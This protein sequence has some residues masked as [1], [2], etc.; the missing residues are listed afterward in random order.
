M[1]IE[2]G[3]AEAIRMVQHTRSGDPT[4]LLN[5]MQTEQDQKNEGEGQDQNL[6]MN[7][8]IPN[9]LLMDEDITFRSKLT[10]YTEQS[11]QP[12]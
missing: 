5:T 6:L 12:A 3:Q 4:A 8:A 9:N 7:E 10:N 2:R 11:L 1:T